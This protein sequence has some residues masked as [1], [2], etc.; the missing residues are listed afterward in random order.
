[1]LDNGTLQTGICQ[2]K[3]EILAN[4]RVRL[5]ETWKWT[6]GDFSEGTSMIE[7]I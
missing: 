4:G 3:P 5:H 1:V 2:S 6:S 7:E